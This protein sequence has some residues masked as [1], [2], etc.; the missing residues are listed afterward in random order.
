MTRA[1]FNDLNLKRARQHD[2]LPLE[3]SAVQQHRFAWQRVRYAPLIHDSAWSPRVDVLG[4][5]AEKRKV[6]RRH[7]G[8][9]DR[10]RR[11]GNGDFKRRTRGKSAAHRHIT[12]HS[13]SDR[14]HR[15]SNNTKLRQHASRVAHPSRV[16]RR[17]IG[18][19]TD[20]VVAGGVSNCDMSR[21]RNRHRQHRSARVIN[22][23]SDEI[24][25]TGRMCARVA[26]TT[27]VRAM[28]LLSAVARGHALDLIWFRATR[29]Q[30]ACARDRASHCRR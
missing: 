8:A 5:L 9:S 30:A 29:P 3:A 16:A 21:Q 10:K 6:T 19:F 13:D 15:D 27:E 25:A 22:M 17:F 18:P 24:H 14:R 4:A 23:V 20:E 28:Q 11:A 2:R 12:R 26:R 1:R 7:R